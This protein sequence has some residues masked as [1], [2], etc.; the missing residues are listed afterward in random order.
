MACAFYLSIYIVWCLHLDY[1][2]DFSVMSRFSA[3]GVHFSS[4]A[5]IVTIDSSVT[6]SDSLI[7]LH[8]AF[9]A[10]S[11]RLLY[12]S[13]VSCLLAY[14]AAGFQFSM[15]TP[16]PKLD[17]SCFAWLPLW[18]LPSQAVFQRWSFRPRQSMG[19]LQEGLFTFSAGSKRRQSL[20]TVR[21][22]A[23]MVRWI[24]P[25]EFK[26]LEMAIWVYS[27]YKG[28]NPCTCCCNL[29]IFKRFPDVGNSLTG[30][31]WQWL[32]GQKIMPVSFC[33]ETLAKRH[34][35]ESRLVVV[36]DKKYVK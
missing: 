1:I 25:T 26:Q 31:N 19:L 8:I 6:L 28:S 12:C 3:T 35:L 20:H 30:S 27:N 33:Q 24:I 16:W 23:W 9:V 34:H 17:L 13:F 22:F 4:P 7:W 11:I 2:S 18:G 32:A 15:L 14:A 36:N 21:I 29:P 5:V 10:L